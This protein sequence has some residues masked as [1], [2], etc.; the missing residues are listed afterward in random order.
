MRP[1]E[2]AT[3]GGP[4]PQGHFICIDKEQMAFRIEL[5]M[6]F[7]L[8]VVPVLE[9]FVDPLQDIEGHFHLRV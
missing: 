1:F 9:G 4:V 8:V 3:L 2:S 6:T 7:F 5:G